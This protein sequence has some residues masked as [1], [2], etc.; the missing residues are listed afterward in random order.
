MT[1]VYK[2]LLF[3]IIFA[4]MLMAGYSS[5]LFLDKRIKES[6]TGWEIFGYSFLLLLV[7]GVLFIGGLFILIKS[8]AFLVDAE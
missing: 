3:L 2:L 4:L 7:N 6:E 8:Y 5:F 1:A